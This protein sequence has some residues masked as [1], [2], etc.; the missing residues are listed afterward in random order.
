MARPPEIQTNLPLLPEDPFTTP[1]I[2]LNA[3]DPASRKKYDSYVNR[4]YSGAEL[5]ARYDRL[6]AAQ[7]SA[8][9]RIQ[10]PVAP[11]AAREEA[12][13]SETVVSEVADRSRVETRKAAGR[14]QELDW[15]IEDK[16]R[17]GEEYS[18]PQ[19]QMESAR[20][21]QE[22]EKGYTKPASLSPYPQ[23]VTGADTRDVS[24]SRVFQEA[25][26]PEAVKEVWRQQPLAKPKGRGISS[27]EGAAAAAAIEFSAW[28]SFAKQFGLPMGRDWVSA[29]DEELSSGTF[30][31]DK[32]NAWKSAYTDFT[33]T[34]DMDWYKKYM[35][36]QAEVLRRNL[37]RAGV[38]GGTAAYNASARVAKQKQNVWIRE[39]EKAKV[40]AEF[41]YTRQLTTKMKRIFEQALREEAWDSGEMKPD[42]EQLL[43]DAETM[44]DQYLREWVSTNIPRLDMDRA[45]RVKKQMENIERRSSG[46]LEDIARHIG[47]DVST[48]LYEPS[49]SVMVESEFL[50]TMRFV[51]SPVIRAVAEGVLMPF[52]Y[53]RLPGGQPVDPLDI[54]YLAGKKFSEKNRE[55]Y[56]KLASGEEP[57]LIERAKHYSTY[58]G[59][60]SLALPRTEGVT[61]IST[62]TPRR[63]D[64]EKYGIL[65]PALAHLSGASDAYMM[66]VL[67]GWE[68]GRFTLEDVQAIEGMT[69]SVFGIPAM[70][71][72]IGLELAI[73]ISP[74]TMGSQVIR[75]GQYVAGGAAK[76]ARGAQKF[77][78][79]TLYN[80]FLESGLVR[81]PED[82]AA[83]LNAKTP[84]VF[85]NR[86]DVMADFLANPVTTL[87]AKYG[88]GR[89]RVKMTVEASKGL[90]GA[91]TNTRWDWSSTPRVMGRWL[92]KRATDGFVE[93]AEASGKPEDFGPLLL[94]WTQER[95][96]Q[97]ADPAIAEG[98]KRMERA[99]QA[100][101][102]LLKAEN[103]VQTRTLI[104]DI[105]TS[106]LLQSKQVQADTVF[107]NGNLDVLMTR[108][109]KQK[110]QRPA[111]AE[112]KKVAQTLEKGRDGFWEIVIDETALNNLFK[113]RPPT[114]GL[115]RALKRMESRRTQSKMKLFELSPHKATD[116]EQRLLFNWI[117]STIMLRMAK[118]LDDGVATLIRPEAFK[119]IEVP[120]GIAPGKIVD[121]FPKDSRGLLG[122]AGHQV[123]KVIDKVPVFR[124]IRVGGGPGRR[125]P[126]L[127]LM[128]TIAAR[129][130]YDKASVLRGAVRGEEV[131]YAVR[132][133]GS[134]V[135]RVLPDVL[136]PAS[137][138]MTPWVNPRV[139]RIASNFEQ[140][141]YDVPRAFNQMMIDAQ[142][143]YKNPYDAF[144]SVLQDIWSKSADEGETAERFYHSVFSYYL[145]A[146]GR[147]ESLLKPR[148]FETAADYSSSAE[149]IWKTKP[150]RRVE[151]SLSEVDL[152]EVMSAYKGLMG[153]DVFSE[154]ENL[155]R[156]LPDFLNE[157]V[158]AARG[159]ETS[160]LMKLPAWKSSLQ[161]IL[162]GREGELGFLKTTALQN[163]IDHFGPAFKE[164]IR[165]EGAGDLSKVK[166][167]DRH[168][169][170]AVAVAAQQEMVSQKFTEMADRL[171]TEFPELI[172]KPQ[173]TESEWS[174]PRGGMQDL[175]GHESV[176]R[177]I[178]SGY[179]EKLIRARFGTDPKKVYERVLS[180]FFYGG[181]LTSVGL[182]NFLKNNI[183][184][185]M[186][187]AG[188]AS[189]QDDMAAYLDALD[190]T[191]KRVMFGHPGDPPPEFKEWNDQVERWKTGLGYHPNLDPRWID[192]D[193]GFG[194]A[195]KDIIDQYKQ[196][197]A[198]WEHGE[199]QSNFFD[200]WAGKRVVDAGPMPD[201]RNFGSTP[202]FNKAMQHWKERNTLKDGEWVSVEES[203]KDDVFVGSLNDI[204]EKAKIDHLLTPKAPEIASAYKTLFDTDTM[205][206]VYDKVLSPG[207]RAK[208]DKAAQAKAPDRNYFIPL[209]MED[210][211]LQR[212][213]LNDYMA[214]TGFSEELAQEWRRTGYI[215]QQEGKH[216]GFIKRMREK[217][218]E[219][220]RVFADEEID[221]TRD[222][223][224][225]E[226]IANL[227][228]DATK[229]VERAQTSGKYAYVRPV[230]EGMD[231]KSIANFRP[232]ELDKIMQP[233]VLDDVK[234]P[235]GSEE[236]R[237]ANLQLLK[238][239]GGT[240][241]VLETLNDFQRRGLGF[242]TGLEVVRFERGR[243]SEV[244]VIAA[245]EK[246]AKLL[247]LFSTIKTP[248]KLEGEATL[249]QYVGD[250]PR[251]LSRTVAQKDLP[252]AGRQRTAEFGFEPKREVFAPVPDGDPR[253]PFM[254]AQIKAD[255]LGRDLEEA[256]GVFR[257]VNPSTAWKELKNNPER[258]QQIIAQAYD[259]ALY[260]ATSL[261][262]ADIMAGLNNAG[263]PIG[264][265]D[266][267]QSPKLMPSMISL[268]DD[269]Y[270]LGDPVLARTIDLV[271][272]KAIEG[273]LGRGLDSLR[274][275]EN[276]GEALLT[277]IGSIWLASRRMQASGL[278]GI[279][280]RYQGTNV[281][282]WP[283]IQM[284]TNPSMVA[285]TLSEF[286][287]DF[288]EAARVSVAKEFR[289][290]GR[291]F[292]L[293]STA[294]FGDTRTALQFLQDS[295]DKLK[296][297]YGD[298]FDWSVTMQRA[299]DRYMFSHKTATVMQAPNGVKY[300]AEML[301]DM[302]NSKGVFQTQVAF[303]FSDT[304][305]DDLMRVTRLNKDL[306][307]PFMKSNLRGV[308][309][310][311]TNAFNAFDPRSKN[312]FNRFAM[313]MDQSYRRAAFIAA[314]SLGL[315]EDAAALVARTAVLDYGRTTKWEK[316]ILAR[317][318]LFYSFQRNMLVETLEA[319]ARGDFSAAALFKWWRNQEGFKKVLGTYAS[320]PNYGHTRAFAIPQEG[321][322]T[323][324]VD[325]TETLWLG[326]GMPMLDALQSV[327]TIASYLQSLA[328]FGKKPD[329]K[330]KMKAAVE[331][332]LAAPDVQYV[333]GIYH[334][335]R[336]PDAPSRYLNPKLIMRA[337]YTGM[338]DIW[339]EQFQ[340]KRTTKPI[341][342]GPQFLDDYTNQKEQYRFKN[343]KYFYKF[344]AMTLLAL[345]MNSERIM[346]E[347]ATFHYIRTG[348]EAED[349]KLTRFKGGLA[350]A[351]KYA[352]GWYTPVAGQAEWQRNNLVIKS[353]EKDMG[354]LGKKY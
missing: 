282:T 139:I 301:D 12:P 21:V 159:D 211:D 168:F 51:A 264:G 178:L 218:E 165:A 163:A 151:E 274:K 238:E 89:S 223:L 353:L 199:E 236:Y 231:P 172:V 106:V 166:V 243:V 303:E 5:K 77:A 122:K 312:V 76:A 96:Q 33:R 269:V 328:P 198:R 20:K 14:Q 61:G 315:D 182:Q 17:A 40:K 321:T 277:N 114:P 185:M 327:N 161:R 304:D 98:F 241:K 340:L 132:M 155:Q 137:D 58:L 38:Y 318:R 84:S 196:Q 62:P 329:H 349:M 290:T 190:P 69:D 311:A 233:W 154:M 252:P 302:M 31:Q 202:E 280:P 209:Y 343:D 352:L 298:F 23:A 220:Y 156:I 160:K 299:Y 67:E 127:R 80:M 70:A 222:W 124:D 275:S 42:E 46:T 219:V 295:L 48:W 306:T 338:W 193:T 346:N 177:H 354:H 247:D 254:W 15:L 94:R 181:D 50:R 248:K 39:L 187:D 115:Q 55:Y 52:T 149:D 101:P 268:K 203:L 261:E 44:A 158:L 266:L 9:H 260:R 300:T 232:D 286:T 81:S 244:A 41:E 237:A 25:G 212:E 142:Q 117:E 263:F 323:E 79:P 189:V 153:E 138:R 134:F 345:T 174:L 8:L 27:D 324:E 125:I 35:P 191:S 59:I 351:I 71:A 226:A 167:E 131:P 140:E 2:D 43:K 325:F 92:A 308:R 319:L 242:P 307:D 194:T 297:N 342:G 37:Q 91:E 317:N 135:Q 214:R 206:T 336:D 278:M 305:I 216:V 195:K 183:N 113:V 192:Q 188:V 97:A 339:V 93:F 49:E 246:N 186:S 207:A 78:Q 157:V 309:E 26:L 259:D 90:K 310:A 171:M 322:Q 85:N 73:P 176:Y 164:F 129:Q 210:P 201:R 228:R 255:E 215:A 347:M 30:K 180:D 204:I 162:A 331:F 99:L 348:H 63:T 291:R 32:I 120:V 74:L 64:P 82:L 169:M 283:L 224:I 208:I 250:D 7:Q 95:V 123:G 333:L 18:W 75:A 239:W 145:N 288:F 28:E 251:R 296:S 262:V 45:R 6:I 112:T 136:K 68:S 104:E 1:G 258:V 221:K 314:L 36:E 121:Y 4:G 292:G 253:A 197:L 19:L 240:E 10:N 88:H 281:I 56:E 119:G 273:K 335:D 83:A 3:L 109:T 267:S 57:S 289:G 337:K 146:K 249:V 107:A 102:E 53:D 344:G 16:V 276:I 279:S 205:E 313:A 47:E 350:P 271:R 294:E 150:V 144:T 179:A 141:A 285:R 111:Q 265:S 105:W 24:P 230:Y 11:P 334:N 87:A 245:N 227:Q 213:V 72:A 22:F 60:P 66:N 270:L 341:A 108:A 86:L 316:N 147:Q 128:Q 272:G 332:L 130:G 116:N 103:A 293:L 225:Y 110:I 326:P 217:A 330:N 184:K 320:Q 175:E 148:G 133:A 143:E 54:N 234:F 257:I 13:A 173:R 65:G 34:P 100:N 284:V 126:A 152:Y 229:V 256:E 287:A 118:E 235:P 170:A 200:M 29:S